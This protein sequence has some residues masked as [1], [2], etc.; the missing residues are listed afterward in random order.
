MTQQTTPAAYRVGDELPATVKTIRQDK[1]ARYAEVAGDHNPLHVDPEFAATTQ[2]GGTVAHGM[3]VLAYLSEMLTGAFGQRWIA[4]GRLKAR[5]RAP[6]RPGDTVTAAGRVTKIE[7][8]VLRCE[9]ECRNQDG[10]ALITADVE[11]PA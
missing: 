2:F 3:L 11:V 6:A 4:G 8:G 1:I 9:A 7:N 10:E 5:F